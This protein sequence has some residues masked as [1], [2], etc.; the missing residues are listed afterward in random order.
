MHRSELKNRFFG[1]IDSKYFNGHPDPTRP[2]F[3]MSLFRKKKTETIKKEIEEPRI[4]PETTHQRIITAEGWHRKVLGKPT[5][6]VI[7]KRS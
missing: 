1:E 3:V 6:V 7:K 4:L 2:R 5:E